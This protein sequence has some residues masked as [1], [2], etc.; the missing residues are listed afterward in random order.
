MPDF[1]VRAD[2]VDVEQIMRQIRGR[3][4]DKRGVDYTEDQIRELAAAKLE[5][6]LDPTGV[7]SD[8]LEQFRSRP[9]LPP[10]FLY[11]FEDTTLFDSD[12]PI[13]RFFRRLLHP[14]LKLLFN[15]NVLSSTLHKQAAFNQYVH[16]HQPLHFELLHNLVLELTRTSIE[17]K[18]LRMR[19]ESVQ[20]RLEFNER[21]ARALEAVVEYKAEAAGGRRRDESQ[22]ERRSEGSRAWQAQP[23]AQQWQPQPSGQPRLAQQ[24]TARVPQQARPPQPPPVEPAAAVDEAGTPGTEP[25]GGV[26][27]ITGG[28]SLRTRRRRRRR[29][30]RGTGETGGS[31]DSGTWSTASGTPETG[32]PGTTPADEDAAHGA[33]DGALKPGV[34]HT[35]GAHSI[36][37]SAPP[38]GSALPA[39]SADAVRSTSGTGSTGQDIGPG[40]TSESVPARQNARGTWGTASPM[41]P[42]GAAVEHAAQGTPRQGAAANPAATQEPARADEPASAPGSG[43]THE[44]RSTLAASSPSEP[45]A[46]RE[47]GPDIG[48]TPAVAR[49]G[50]VDDEPQ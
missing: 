26:D 30:R 24:Q 9:S 18:N 37:H 27:P 5:R 38:G 20:S 22:R 31:G 8:L 2:S 42:A 39:D 45:G 47:G 21:R 34:I 46:T 23:R 1:T 4:R 49:P 17:V 50:M 43:A 3:I 44:S 6:F 32:T 35:V 15:P 33:A 40:S 7:R 41:Q 28:E 10:G 19:L 29:G 48:T 12:K 13:V 36:P 14:F 11:Q 16:A 25:Q